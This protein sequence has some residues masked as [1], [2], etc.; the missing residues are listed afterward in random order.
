MRGSSVTI[1]GTNSSFEAA[2]T[3]ASRSSV[4]RVLPAS[5]VGSGAPYAVPVGGTVT[6]IAA[7]IVT[8]IAATIV[9]AIDATIARAKA[10]QGND[11]RLETRGR[12]EQVQSVKSLLMSVSIDKGEGKIWP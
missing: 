5:E 1:T 11:S 7:T 9:A 4:N 8:P 3:R 6:P 2:A 10:V 12:R